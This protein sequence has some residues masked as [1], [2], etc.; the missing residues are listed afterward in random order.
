MKFGQVYRRAV[1]I[2]YKVK[3]Q[4]EVFQ[5][6]EQCASGKI[7]FSVCKSDGFRLIF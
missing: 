4:N 5:I 1:Q 3:E 6:L 7:W 2:S